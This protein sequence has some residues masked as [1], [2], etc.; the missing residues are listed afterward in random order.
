MAISF[1]NN[2]SS[3]TGFEKAAAF[4]NIYVPTK[5]GTKKKLGFI[6]LK[7]SNPLHQQIISKADNA[8]A[9]SKLINMLEFD[10]HVV[11]QGSEDEL[12]I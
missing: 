2:T 1:N 6:A 12:D 9:M 8:E 7:E 3:D 5:Q 10:V 4:I 11:N